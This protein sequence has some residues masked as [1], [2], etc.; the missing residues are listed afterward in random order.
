M[1]ADITSTCETGNY[2]EKHF[3]YDKT[4]RDKQQSHH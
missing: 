4:I 2:E 1:Q 3:L